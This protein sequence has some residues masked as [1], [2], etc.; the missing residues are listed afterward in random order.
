MADKTIGDLTEADTLDGTELVEIEQDGN[1]RKVTAQVLAELGGGGIV[2]DYEEFLSSGTYNVPEGATYVYVELVG[3][4]GG[5]GNNTAN[6]FSCG[7]GGGGG[8]VAGLFK[9]DDLSGTVAVTIGA[10]GSGG[11]NGGNNAGSP[12]G[13]STF[14]AILVANG[15]GGG[16]NTVGNN[17]K[18]GGDGGG[19]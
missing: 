4:G 9:A 18:G 12:G 3:G 13:N 10:G 7:G 1:S 19:G 5:G 2:A 16:L 8:F 11:A 6:N 17:L 15:G 14:G